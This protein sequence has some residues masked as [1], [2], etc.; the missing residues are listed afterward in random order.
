MT[1]SKSAAPLP[2]GFL[3]IE[4]LYKRV[5]EVRERQAVQMKID[6]GRGEKKNLSSAASKTANKSQ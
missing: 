1:R 6:A 4:A 2:S 5:E 3:P